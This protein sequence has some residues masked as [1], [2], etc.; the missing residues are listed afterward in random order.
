MRHNCVPP[1]VNFSILYAKYWTKITS[2]HNCL[3]PRVHSI[4]AVTL[5][6]FSSPF[7]VCSGLREVYHSKKVEDLGEDMKMPA[8]DLR[9]RFVIDLFDCVLPLLYNIHQ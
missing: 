4:F 7:T 9:S 2:Q 6:F 8:L 5:E 1:I 3:P